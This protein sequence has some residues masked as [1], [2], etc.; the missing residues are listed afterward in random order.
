MK[1]KCLITLLKIKIRRVYCCLKK[2]SKKPFKA[3]VIAPS[4]VSLIYK[5][6]ISGYSKD[7]FIKDLVNECVKD[8]K[9]CIA[10]GASEIGMDMTEATYAMKVD[11]TGKVLNP[12][13][14]RLRVKEMIAV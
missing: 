2:Y 11:K 7:Q 13:V 14:L 12:S 6:E 5:D 3:T 1:Q 9:K 4:A 8:V 10:S